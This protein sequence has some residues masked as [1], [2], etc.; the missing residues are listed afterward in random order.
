M[1][2]DLLLFAAITGVIA[3]SFFVWSLISKKDSRDDSR[4]DK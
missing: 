3:L 2:K 1:L 4:D